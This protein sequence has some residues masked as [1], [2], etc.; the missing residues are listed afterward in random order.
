MKNYL[1]IYFTAFI[2]YFVVDAAYQIAFGL[3]LDDY[4]FSQ[5]GIKDIFNETVK[6]PLSFLIFFILISFANLEL[7]IR[8]AMQRQSINYALTRGALLGATVYMNLALPNIW[9]IKDYPQWQLIHF[10]AT[11]A[12]FC[13]VTCAVCV[14][15][16]KSR[17]L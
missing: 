14:R 1:Q 16:F 2:V 13:M 3:R 6:W 7:V 17:K 15:V 8:P 12:V 4:L 10:P 9:L 11:G 5:A